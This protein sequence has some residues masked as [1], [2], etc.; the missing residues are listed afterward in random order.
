MNR[1]GKTKASRDSIIDNAATLMMMFKG[2]AELGEDD[3]DVS[4]QLQMRQ[5]R[6]EVME[7]TEVNAVATSLV[8]E[9]L[10]G[11]PRTRKDGSLSPTKAPWTHADKNAL[12]LL[13]LGCPINRSKRHRPRKGGAWGDE[14]KEKV[15]L[16]FLV[17]GSIVIFSPEVRTYE[18]AA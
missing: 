2:E 9:Q 15:R 14:A 7:C 11:M 12:P 16:E 5:Q 18:Q 8:K 13:H 6:H 3:D 4:P 1:R 10:E 17:S